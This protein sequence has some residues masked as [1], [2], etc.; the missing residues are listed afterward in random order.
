[1]AI[2]KDKK[3]QILE[4]L[5]KIV[6]DSKNI[7]FVSFTKLTVANASLLRRKMRSEGVGYYVAKKTLLKKALEA[8]KYQGTMPELEGELGIAYSQDLIA[9]AREAWDFQKKLDGVVKLVGGIFDG[10]YMNKDEITAIAAIPP[11]KTLHAQFVNLIN[12]PIQGFVM[13]LS[14]IS[15]KKTN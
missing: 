6:K 11:L 4:K 9:P 15:K 5:Q 3:K 12:S 2:S 1:M 7:S 13:A 14:E 8:G 10:R